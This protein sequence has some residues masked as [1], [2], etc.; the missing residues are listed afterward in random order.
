MQEEKFSGILSFLMGDGLLA[1]WAGQT[2]KTKRGFEGFNRDIKT[3]IE[4]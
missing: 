2:E 3:W 4:K 1:K